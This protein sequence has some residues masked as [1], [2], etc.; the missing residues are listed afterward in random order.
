MA[1]ITVDVGVK[2]NVMQSSLA[3]L[4]KVLSHLEPDSAGFK[5]LSK[6]IAEMTREMEKFQVQTSKGFTS[7][8]QFDQA[9]RSIEKMEE[10]LTKA[11]IAMSNLKFSDIKLDANQTK[12]FNELEQAIVTAEQRLDSIKE[13][14]KQGIFSD[15]AAV[16]TLRALDKNGIQKSF[17]EI[18]AIV[19]NGTKKIEGDLINAKAKFD[20]L[21]RAVSEQTA[22]SNKAK[23]LLSNGITQ[24]DWGALLN[25][26]GTGFK[27]GGKQ[28]FLKILKD[29]FEVSDADIAAL[30]KMTFGKINEA[31]KGNQF[32][33]I[34]KGLNE[35]LSKNSSG[36][37][38]ARK[39][40]TK[41]EELQ[42]AVDELHTKMAASKESGTPLGQGMSAYNAEI[43]RVA[44]ALAKLRGEA[45]QNV[46]TNSTFSNSISAMQGQLQGFANQLDQASAAF[47][48]LQSQQQTFN[49]IKMAIT[50]FMGFNQILNLTKTAVR[51]AMNHIKELDSVMNGISI[52]TNMS[53]AD[54][55][56]QVDA[57]SAMAQNFG[58]SIKGAYEVSQIYYQ[59]GLETNDVLNLTNETLK[60]CK[61]SGLDYAQATDYMTTAIRGFKMEMS[62]ASNVVDVY[63]NL[64]ANTAVSQEE[65]AVAMSKTASSMESV[66]STFEETSAMIA[67]MV[68]VTRES[69][70]NIGSAMKS[71]ASRYGELTK[72]PSKMMD[73]DGEAMVFNKVDAALQSVGISM[74]TVDGQFREF[75]DVILEL[76]GVWDQLTSVQ[77]RYIATQF[78]GNRQQSRFLALVGNGDLLRE[79]IEIAENSEDAGTLQ[80][81]KALDSLE[82]KLNQVQVAYQQF[83]TTIGIESVWKG[84]LDGIKNFINSL[85]SLPKVFGVIPVG[86]ATVIMDAITLI[87]NG[88]YAGLQGIVPI[89]MNVINEARD[90]TVNG[91]RS[92]GQEAGQAFT[93]GMNNSISNSF[94]NFIDN[95]IN[96]LHSK[97]DAFNAAKANLMNW[98]GSLYNEQY[99]ADIRIVTG[100]LERLGYISNDTAQKL[101]N[102]S[103]DQA[104]SKLEE[105]GLHANNT[106][107]RLDNLKQRAANIG[108]NF[109]NISM[110]LNVF[111]N[112]LDKTSEGGRVLAGT[113][114]TV[115]G[116]MRIID[117]ITKAMTGGN[118]WMALAM[119][120]ITLINGINTIIETPQEKLER[121]TKQAEEL[122]NKAKQVK[123]DYKTLDSSID[124]LKELEEKRYDSAEAAD[125]YK[126]AVEELANQF[127]QLVVALDEAGNATIETANLD[128]ELEK[129]RKASA[130]ATL[131]A[132][133]AEREKVQQELDN[134]EA[135]QEKRYKGLTA[136]ADLYNTPVNN[137]EAYQK[138]LN[139]NLMGLF[140]N[141]GGMYNQASTNKNTILS[142]LQSLMFNQ[143]I[144]TD[145]PIILDP[146]TGNYIVKDVEQLKEKLNEAR[147]NLIEEF[148]QDILGYSE[149]FDDL[150]NGVISAEAERGDFDAIQNVSDRIAGLSTITDESTFKTELDNIIKDIESNKLNA[151]F[152][153]FL[154]AVGEYRNGI[155]KIQDLQSRLQA[156]ENVELSAAINT[157]GQEQQEFVESLGQA[158]GLLTAWLKSQ[159]D[160][161]TANGENTLD[162]YVNNALKNDYNNFS[163]KF[164]ELGPAF[165][166]KLTEIWG[167][168]SQYSAN[169]LI[170][171]LDIPEKNPLNDAIQLYYKNN[172]LDS[173]QFAINLQE[174]MEQLWG[175]EKDDQNIQ[176][177]NL[178][179]KADL[180]APIREGIIRLYNSI[181]QAQDNI[182]KDLN[183]WVSGVID[184]VEKYRGEGLTG[185]ANQ[186]AI[187]TA[188]ILEE[189]NKLGETDPN[190]AAQV[191]NIL[192]GASLTSIDGITKTI[193]A[194]SKILPENSTIITSL[195]NLKGELTYNLP[196]SI[197]AFTDSIVTQAE[198]IE[199]SIK[200]L[201]SGVSIKDAVSILDTV[202]QSLKEGQEQFTLK[203]LKSKNGK[204]YFDGSARAAE[205]R[206]LYTQSLLDS[207]D[208]ENEAIK[209]EIEGIKNKSSKAGQQLNTLAD[210]LK[211]YQ[212]TGLSLTDAIFSTDAYSDIFSTLKGLGLAEETKEGYFKLTEKAAKMGVDI[213]TKVPELLQHQLETGESTADYLNRY[214]PAMENLKAGEYK[215]YFT[216]LGATLD[217]TF[218]L[219]K[220]ASGEIKEVTGITK[221]EV[222]EAKEKINSEFDKLVNDIS[223][224]GIENIDLND[225]AL[226]DIITPEDLQQPAE[227]FIRQ[228]GELLGKTPKE[229]DNLI[230]QVRNI[231]FEDNIYDA[232]N[233]VVS[234]F[235]KF[236]YEAGQQLIRA[237]KF[238]AAPEDL[239]NVDPIT[240]ELSS[241]YEQMLKFLNGSALD[242]T[243]KQYLELRA[244][245]EK[246]QAE[247]DRTSQFADI[248]SQR[249]KL[250]ED[251]IA[252]LAEIFGTTYDR[253]QR[254]LSQNADGSYSM[255]LSTIQEMIDKGRITVS[256][257]IKEIIANE[258]DSIISSLT[259]LGQLQGKG[260]TSIEDMQKRVG[261]IN[262]QLGTDFKMQDLFTYN[263]NL[264]AFTYSTQG[265]QLQAASLAKELDSLKQNTEANADQIWAVE[266]SMRNIAIEMANNIDV[267][268][269]LG[270]AIG[271]P[272]RELKIDEL[273]QALNDYNTVLGELGETEGL[274]T[275]T[276]INALRL[277]GNQAVQAA[278]AIAAA[279]GTTLS[280]SDVEAAYRS[281][282]D[283][284]INAIDTI[285]SQP[286]AIVDTMTAEII[287]ISG[288]K[289]TELGNTGQFVVQSAAN[290]YEA[291]K[292][293]L[294]GMKMTG[295]ATLA[296]LN[297]VVALALENRDGEQVVIDALGDAA[298]M[299]FSRF[300][301]ILADAGIELSEN[302]INQLEASG[303]VDLMGGNKMRIADFSRFADLMGWDASS[304]EYVSAFKTYNDS[305]ISMNRQAESNILEEVSA[306]GDAKGGDWLN[307]T[308]LSA[309]LGE[310][311]KY[312]S[313]TQLDALTTRLHTLGAELED[314]ILKLDS[315]A[316][317]PG[318]LA[319]IA[320]Y[321][322]QYGGLL[323]QDMAE[324]ADVLDDVLSSYAD[325]IGKG[326]NGKLTN[327][328]AL[329]LQNMTN[330]LGI[331]MNLDFT[332][333]A[334]GLKLSQQAAIG[335]YQELQ[336]IDSI[337]AQLVF[338]DVYKSLTQVGGGMENISQTT[339]KVEQIQR[340]LAQ[341]YA[342]IRNESV[343]VLGPDTERVDALQAQNAELEAQLSLYQQIQTRQ[344]D[345]PNSYK[346]MDQSLPNYMQGA[347]NYWN[348]VGKAFESM[349]EAGKT[350][351]MS[352]QDFRNIVNEMN[353]MAAMTGSDLEFMGRTLNGSAESASQLIQEGMSHLENIDGK[354]VKINM[355]NFGLD[356][357]SGAEGM[358][359][360]F[361]EGI[362][363]MAQS[364]IDM[365]DAAIQMLEVV[366]AMEK[367]G[368]IDIDEDN[369]LDLSE[370]FNVETP[371][372]G[373]F[374]EGFH[375]W[376]V[377]VEEQAKTNKDLEK[378][379]K[380]ISINGHTMSELIH[381]ATGSLEDQ[382][383]QFAALNM[384]EQ[385]YAAVMDAFY[386]AAINGDYDLEHLQQSVWEI[387][388]KTLPDGTVID[389]GNRSIVISG[390][391]HYSI[392]WRSENVQDALELFTGK[393]EEKKQQ[394]KDAFAHY[395]QGEGSEIEVKSVLVAKGL[396]DVDPQTGD[397]TTPDGKTYKAGTPEAQRAIGEAALKAAGIDTK[398]KDTKVQEKTT[399]DGKTYMSVETTAKIGN[400]TVIAFTDESGNVRYHSDKLNQDFGSQDELI[401]AEYELLISSREGKGDERELPSRDQYAYLEYG[402]TI[403]TKTTIKGADGKETDPATNS[404]VRN[405]IEQFILATKN[406]V[407]QAL[408]EGQAT[409]TD[410]QNGTHTLTLL[411]GSSITFDTQNLDDE[412]IQ[413]KAKQEALNALGIDTLITAI[414]TAIT[415]AFS[416]DN[417]NQIGEALGKGIKNALTIK[418]DKD[419]DLTDAPVPEVSLPEVSIKP[420]EISF[421][422]S[423]M[424]E[425]T[426][427]GGETVNVDI[428]DVTVKPSK[429]HLDTAEMPT[430]ESTDTTEPPKV[431]IAEVIVK[432]TSA[433]LD[434]TG[435]GEPQADTS[436]DAIIPSVPVAEAI[437]KPSAGKLDTTSMAEIVPDE[438]EIIKA[439]VSNLTIQPTGTPQI[440]SGVEGTNP[441]I[442]VMTAD[443]TN[444]TVNS[445]GQPTVKT[446][447]GTNPVIAAMTADVTALTLDAAAPTFSATT[448]TA[449]TSAGTDLATNVSTGLTN[450]ASVVTT[451]ASGLINTINVA[452]GAAVAATDFK[453]A[454]SNIVAGIA[455]GMSGNIVAITMAA[456]E[457]ATK[458]KSAVET[459]LGIA[460]PSTVMATTGGYVAQGL[461]EGMNNDT[462]A[463][464][465][466]ITLAEQVAE[467]IQSKLDDISVDS[468]TA[469]ISTVK[470][471]SV[472]SATY[473]KTLKIDDIEKGTATVKNLTVN[474][475]SATAG[476]GLSA[477]Q[478]MDFSNASTSLGTLSGYAGDISGVSFGNFS[479]L[480]DCLNQASSAAQQVWEYVK[481][482]S[483]QTFTANIQVQGGDSTI[484]TTENKTTNEVHNI[485]ENTE[486]TET[487][488]INENYNE[489]I[490]VDT[491]GAQQSTSQ[492]GGAAASMG[493]QAN[494]SAGQ[495]KT[496]QTAL[497]QVGSAAILAKAQINNLKTAISQAG[498]AA[499]SAKSNISN[500]KTAMSNMPNPAENVKNLKSAMTGIPSNAAS[501]VS[502]LAEAMRG[503]P[504]G[505][506]STSV[507]LQY[508]TQKVGAA[509]GNMGGGSFAK[510]TNRALVSG[511][512]KTLMGE[513]GPELV[514]SNGRYFIAGQ[515][516]AE[517]VDLAKDAIVF[518]HKQTRR[519]FE[520]GMIGSRGRPITNESNAISL[521]KG[522]IPWIGPARG[523]VGQGSGS[524]GS[525]GGSSGGN[526]G[527][528]K[529]ILEKISSVSVSPSQSEPIKIFSMAKG[530]IPSAGPALASAA[531]ALA[532]LKEL[533]AMW[534]S[535]LDAGAKELGSM[536]GRDGGGGGGGKSCFV[537]GTL[538]RVLDG[539]KNIEDIQ[540][541]DLVLSY[542]IDKKINEYSEVVA[543]MIHNTTEAIYSLY[544]EDDIIEATGIHPFFV[545]RDNKIDWIEAENLL[546]GDYVLFAD[547]IWH[548]VY[549]IEVQILSTTVYNFEVS[550]NHNYYVGKNSILVHNKK[551]GGGGKKPSAGKNK[552]SPKGKK[553][554]SCFV[555]GTLIKTNN[556]YKNIEDIQKKDIVLSY[557]EKLHKNEYSE[558]L[559]TMIHDVAEEIYF[560]Y[561]EDEVLQ[562]T[563]I[564]RFYIKRD[565]QINWICAAE[566]QMGDLVLFSD[567]SWHEIENIE[568]Q[569]LF[570]TVYN[571]EVSNNHNYYVGKNSVLAHNK[572]GKGGGGGG[573]G[574]SEG[575]EE[576]I[577][578]PI[579]YGTITEEIQRWYDLLRQIDKLE[580]D[581]SYQQAL[582]KKYESDRVANGE[583][584]YSTYQNELRMLKEEISDQKELASLQKSWYDAKRAELAK[585][586]YAKIFTYN[587]EGLQ[588]YTGSGKPGSKRGLD[589]LEHLNE[590]NAKGKFKLNVEQQLSYLKSV[591]FDLT[592]LLYNDDGTVLKNAY[593]M[594]RDQI[595]RMI[596]DRDGT[597]IDEIKNKE[598]DQ[599][600][601]DIMTQMM[602]NFWSRIDGWRDELDSLYDSYNETAT[603]IQEN[604][605]KQN[606]ILQKLVENE[607]KVEED[608][609]KAIESREQT[610]I[611][612]LKKEQELLKNSTDKFIEGLNKQLSKEKEQYNNKKDQDELTKLQRQL[613]I[614]QRSGG[615]AT[616]IRSLQEQIDNKMQEDYFKKQ[617][618]S[619]NTIKDAADE[620]IKRLEKQIDIQSEILEYQKSHGLLWEEV[621][622][623]MENWA[624]EDIAS[625]IL[626]WDKEFKEKSDLQIQ[627]EL[628]EIRERI[629][630]YTE[631]R[632]NS[633]QAEENF[634]KISSELENDATAKEQLNKIQNEDERAKAKQN[635]ENAAKAAYK[636][637]KDQGYTNDQAQ[638][639]AQEA[640]NKSLSN[641]NSTSV[642]ATKQRILSA[643]NEGK[644]EKDQKTKSTAETNL[645]KWK[646]NE[647]AY[648]AIKDSEGKAQK[649]W[650]STLNS[651]QQAT[652][653]KLYYEN[654][655]NQLENGTEVEK[656]DYSAALNKAATTINNQIKGK[657]GNGNS[658]KTTT[659]IPYY[660]YDKKKKKWTK[661]GVLNKGKT[662]NLVGYDSTKKYVKV[663]IEKNPYWIAKSSVPKAN[664]T[665]LTYTTALS[666]ATEKASAVGKTVTIGGTAKGIA[667]K[668]YDFNV[669][670]GAALGNQDVYWRDTKSKD[671]P[672]YRKLLTKGKWA[673]GNKKIHISKINGLQS[674]KEFS[675]IVIDKIDGKTLYNAKKKKI[676]LTLTAKQLQGIKQSKKSLYQII[677]TSVIPNF[678]F[679]TGGMADFTGPAWLDGTKKKPEAVLNA[680]QTRFLKEDL[681]GNSSN[682]LMSI[683]S[684]LQDS[685]NSTY[686]SSVDNSN[687]VVIE[688]LSLNFEAGTISNDYDARRAGDT[689][690]KEILKIARKTG[691]NSVSRR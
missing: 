343:K 102:M 480:L 405:S 46:S 419:V 542:N 217:E 350:G 58:V 222:A 395:Q 549:D 14:T 578:A 635:A 147:N 127:P 287:K 466:A 231:K 298:G 561:I 202:N 366:V 216:A 375:D 377:W 687:S 592:E 315:D 411:D 379:L 126:T 53:T 426:S 118:P 574:D 1:Q 650:Y 548:R 383:E 359:K 448:L 415:E 507:T 510:G 105:M 86:A 308:Q 577:F 41:Y 452:L 447:E 73:E 617:E 391:T 295:E 652:F 546:I 146:N 305:L 275:E 639:A 531:A 691:N 169:E 150:I 471:S 459:K 161:Y 229:V 131:A 499:I 215:E 553:G 27:A 306:L 149:I 251:N 317:I 602:E 115:A 230:A 689:V 3:D 376:A 598:A 43:E 624:E 477:L 582:R 472:D 406:G 417:G 124:K 667:T 16:N 154:K 351:Y 307:L 631:G 228:Y 615:S 114:M 285:T 90:V 201:S 122:S 51:D 554:K 677:K 48:R 668:G 353:N 178:G 327:A 171:A 500:L 454:G 338:D 364:Q 614:L 106:A 233:G 536:A 141:L 98:S 430:P 163:E 611:D 613:A 344:A 413:E 547:G 545:K 59:Q 455:Q 465:A 259:G 345:D 396:I 136:G 68:A 382:K 77:Q 663:K 493:S 414:S 506:K 673:K 409:L 670:A 581:I 464:S 322:Q 63:S 128:Y 191:S 441:V 184:I 445:I 78:A 312:G 468:V 429:V 520:Q 37:E 495:L 66:G 67:T 444:L 166:D 257:E 35:S 232:L 494:T 440:S 331:D 453:S 177:F 600:R 348:S 333:T 528:V 194:L 461:A 575:E 24:Q 431:P 156:S 65:L 475:T 187:E 628:K 599:E 30:Q 227:D 501:S 482:F 522:R 446:G 567:G 610:V 354:G 152:E 290:L 276:L 129:A 181:H 470:V 314:G 264:N 135:A 491:S 355:N 183:S 551:G 651:S 381:A 492:L 643:E 132:A 328:E 538:V 238:D 672:Q 587:D 533:R 55:W 143:G 245:L 566:L 101:N 61:V 203:D 469:D 394:L 196:L 120:V 255:N 489:K 401:D 435:M 457:L 362:K 256:E 541:G 243:S 304:E 421:N 97:A 140:N 260:T 282:I 280:A 234:S 117:G 565:D 130:E 361:D 185:K 337:K 38:A 518:N 15:T 157:L 207:L 40:L 214:S 645:A 75:T 451:A 84:A 193:E 173:R 145:N 386:Q 616:Q 270:M 200:N 434:T 42:K 647:S 560:L 186:I 483:A 515:N 17:D 385:E 23:N 334:E 289:V 263:E 393:E 325:A 123:N 94:S 21:N 286:G 367:L 365:L 199:K 463:T 390:G 467:A 620:Q 89:F 605:A 261:D 22:A 32:P 294:A 511:T 311:I 340:Q 659:E 607:I 318:I 153:P 572:G 517:F 665:E 478:N 50:N 213:L 594:N 188:N 660:T 416:G 299:T 347:E 113:L 100:E 319:T 220:I 603:N 584:I 221:E 559:Q 265:L 369:H 96:E 206:S 497:N 690:V 170:Q 683:V 26:N 69:A 291:Y 302:M 540:K 57:Y 71:I 8:K 11:Q 180:N 39:E 349:N 519:L 488:N 269:F 388:D 293:L 589:I 597:K 653:D 637:A 619:I 583:K 576:E 237:L 629:Q 56:K 544:I 198:D 622:Y 241:S 192:K 573:G 190:Q 626:K 543:T 450:G 681:L 13:K 460:S 320:S 2:L 568:V 300:G 296:D 397:I 439:Q 436:A 579:E 640:Y 137:E 648:G 160:A 47:L 608:L 485:T 562:V 225:Y 179:E 642:N 356:I 240:G 91:T 301:E 618:D 326:I 87:K 139:S 550:G 627:E 138:L 28:E 70:T 9:E 60:L 342:E 374:T 252:S 107:N 449:A 79:N 277:G 283:D 535:L 363:T 242:K 473:D 671:T 438:G 274:A 571:F 638:D 649:G 239:F 387:L 144:D 174:K 268:G 321:A 593:A 437:I 513:L 654:I 210:H 112:A 656:L 526:S 408:E 352:I 88:L 172:H 486:T 273:H 657:D 205:I 664:L 4:Q 368:D 456:N 226:K 85:N 176:H 487:H 521:A 646:Q 558:V 134:E 570:T 247:Q 490:D 580:Q 148:G 407:D 556:G 661:K 458:I 612:N 236:S 33:D 346:F 537:A 688:N 212:D 74:K 209:K 389:T 49:S 373:D 272:A 509:A 679:A 12:A 433:K 121:L 569:V 644:E 45:V 563:G 669:A 110:A 412:Q 204:F 523:A 474:A 313:Y 539:Y 168:R 249:D 54:L 422:T 151:T 278:E 674:N 636:N 25:K 357:S 284:Y 93:E 82:S 425:V 292:N 633:K 658:F 410:N 323:Q 72:D 175:G 514:V 424:P 601:S 133:K 208:S 534:Q 678:K 370:I 330:G 418:K 92:V 329:D 111:A 476:G 427:E 596:Y 95:Y 258:I 31:F 400:K 623:I 44:Q 420:E 253:I 398:K 442:P 108:N 496:A 18:D 358:Q 103:P 80:A 10:T 676:N 7:G 303:I 590:R 655:Q 604:L 99:A 64:A 384:T 248:I 527:E 109:S 632:D 498:G 606:E 516:G 197:Q 595:K 443:V 360:G 288:G 267:S 266:Q 564:H 167:N 182:S 684:A 5:S 83:Y 104:I 250:N 81:L 310:A 219:F 682:S 324:L 504:T 262:Q 641:Y 159:A 512:R 335:L 479:T 279:Q 423:E 372:K 378:G 530:N 621:R 62:E 155:L 508:R 686:T 555:A 503:I 211:S 189:L 162:Q 223:S 164:Y 244:Q 557:N 662:L 392:N 591:E 404:E 281:Q 588:Q 235:D 532:A 158:N 34:F 371:E 116:A 462:T 402:L 309:K 339:A 19:E 224:N 630:I 316:N 666:K 380:N 254:M 505:N 6:I 332:Q 428:P 634:N 297:K 76:S 246:T 195:N 529:E 119:G 525:S 20:E 685:M 52:V 502:K 142:N 481:Q 29:Q 552:T 336:K 36:L 341:N 484:N 609:Y 432:P 625:S 680:D 586:S 403:N 165:A 524:G 271:D 675:S 585:T 125:E 399:A 218:D